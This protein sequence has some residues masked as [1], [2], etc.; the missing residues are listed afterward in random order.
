MA[1]RLGIIP[2][3]E[4]AWR[5]LFGGIG[6][7]SA[8]DPPTGPAPRA[9]PR[10]HRPRAAGPGGVSV[11]ERGRLRPHRAPPPPPAMELFGP[12]GTM[13]AIGLTEPMLGYRVVTSHMIRPRESLTGSS[14]G[15]GS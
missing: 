1:S 8:G 5:D 2:G 14:P 12:G 10:P 11:W 15:R 6:L 3:W 4:S 9:P 13:R 7:R